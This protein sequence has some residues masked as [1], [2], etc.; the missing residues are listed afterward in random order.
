[1]PGGGK[2]KVLKGRVRKGAPFSRS[3]K[4]GKGDEAGK[5]NKGLLTSTPTERKLDALARAWGMAWG[6]PDRRPIY[7]W[8]RE[9]VNLPPGIYKIP[10]LFQ[11][12][13]SRYLMEPFHDLADDRVRVVTVRMPVRSGKS[14]LAD[15]W[16]PWTF[17]NAP[18]PFMWNMNVDTLARRHTRTRILPLLRGIPAFKELLPEDPR[19]CTGQEIIF[20]NGLPLYVQGPSL[21][22]LQGVPVRNLCESE[23]WM[24]DAG[25][26][27]EAVGRLGDFEELHASK[28]LCEGQ[29]GIE[30]D[31]MDV[32]FRKGHMAEWMVPCLG[33][34]VFFEP[35]SSGL[36]E[37]G[38]KWGL[39]W[40]KECRDEEGNWML[41]R[42]AKSVRYECPRMECRHAH[43]DSAREIWNERGR[44]EG[45]N[46]NAP[47]THRSYHV[48]ATVTRRW[49]L[50]AEELAAALNC[51]ALG[52]SQ[53]LMIYTQ[54]RDAL[55]WSE[56]Q[57]MDF[58]SGPKYDPNSTWP[59]EA[60][61]ILSVDHQMSGVNWGLVVGMSMKGELRRYWF[62]K[63]MGVDEIRAKA[64]EFKLGPRRVIL[65]ASHEPEV[66]H[67][68]CLKYDWIAM[69]GDKRSHF[70]HYVK[71]RNGQERPVQ[72]SYSKAVKVDPGRGTSAQ[73]HRWVRQIAWSNPAIKA[74]VKGLLDRGRIVEPDLDPNSPDEKEYRTQMRGQWRGI[75]RNK[76][77]GQSRFDWKDNQNDHARDCWNQATV[78][79]LVKRCLVDFETEAAGKDGDEAGAGKGEEGGEGAG[80]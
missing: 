62:G 39:V 75:V 70:V 23:L 27:Q 54:K 29:A 22:N 6:V 60:F 4:A 57:V 8:A 1:M 50:L 58:E 73:G 3:S 9:N 76:V 33:C 44:Y 65:D 5:R 28:M 13:R 12:E 25:R 66:I 32:E 17:L 79:A 74:K 42:V 71:G 52:I 67:G 80:N 31:D 10:G 47:G 35:K 68:W 41:G 63:L 37:D 30:E 7:E 20:Q 78:F 14:M 77:T 18:G 2:G 16:M 38:S 51:L 59:E 21:D 36:R 34:G 15:I 40:P 49:D 19:K 11:V 69:V 45:R 24:R 72:K 55:P 46:L 64:E 53:P 48:Y 43:Y 56:N 61:R 26:H